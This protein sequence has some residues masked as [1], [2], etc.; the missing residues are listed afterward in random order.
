MKR[1]LLLTL[2]LIFTTANCF[3][4]KCSCISGTRDKKTGVEYRGGITSSDDYY[5]LLFQRETNY[6]DSTVSPKFS[7]LLNAASRVVLPDS[8]VSAVGRIELLLSNNSKLNIEN[9]R[10]FN[11]QMPF[12]FCISVSVNLT[13]EQ[14]EIISKYPIVTY[15]ALHI[16]TTSFVVKEQKKQ[17]KIATCLVME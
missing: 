16:L 15:T 8:I 2:I 7:L 10:Y 5:S 13:K 3:G 11:N 9:A 6:K 14:L 17:Q 12:G 1:Q 4:Q